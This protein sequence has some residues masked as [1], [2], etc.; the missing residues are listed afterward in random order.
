[1]QEGPILALSHQFVLNL[2]NDN[3]YDFHI[4]DVA[5]N[6]SLST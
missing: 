2:A 6:D 1:M 3:I 5:L 4:F